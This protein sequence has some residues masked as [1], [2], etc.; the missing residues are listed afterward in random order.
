MPPNEGGGPGTHPEAVATTHKIAAPTKAQ[1]PSNPTAATAQMPVAFA[2]RYL[3]AGEATL[4]WAVVR[5][6]PLCGF[7]HRHVIFETGAAEIERAPGCA[8]H[9]VYTVQIVDIV[10]TAPERRRAAA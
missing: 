9:R 2:T 3:A 10:P 4:D 1:D 6:C 8:R 7:S 5:H